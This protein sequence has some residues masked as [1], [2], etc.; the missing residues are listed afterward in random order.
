MPEL[1]EVEVIRRDLAPKV[2]GRRIARARISESRLTRRRGS[3]REV[4]AA[5]AGRRVVR[6]RRRGKFFLFDLGEQS[7][8]VRLGM[9]GQLLWHGRGDAFR[10]DAHTHAVLVFAGMPTTLNYISSFLPQGLVASIENLSF[11]MHFESIQ[12]GVIEFKDISYFVLLIIG[13]LAATAIIL[14]ERKAA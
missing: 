12:R 8:V 1:P 3:P 14:D 13:W 10:P 2:E 6:L 11:Q 5:L 4:E 7:L 9:T